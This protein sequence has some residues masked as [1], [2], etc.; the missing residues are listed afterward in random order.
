MEYQSM[1][2]DGLL[3]DLE[4]IAYLAKPKYDNG[5]IVL[6][7]EKGVDKVNIRQNIDG[8][9]DV[10]VNDKERFHFTTQEV[11][12]LITDDGYINDDSDENIGNSVYVVES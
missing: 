4:N 8:S 12:N 6:E 5:Q 2:V 11:Q 7:I 9:V 10:T 1:S 3:E